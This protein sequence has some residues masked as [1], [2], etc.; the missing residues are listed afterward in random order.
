MMLSCFIC[1][2]WVCIVILCVPIFDPHHD[3]VKKPSVRLF[4]CQT[5]LPSLFLSSLSLFLSLFFSLS[6]IKGFGTFFVLQLNFFVLSEKKK[7]KKRL[8]RKGN[9]SLS[10]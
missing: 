3:H 4:L 1:Y 10:I 6:C 2:S 9:D 5:F 7:K 8:K